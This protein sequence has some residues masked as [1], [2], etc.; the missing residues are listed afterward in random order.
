LGWATRVGSTLAFYNREGR[1]TA[2]ARRELLPPNTGMGVLAVLR[3]LSGNPIG[4]I[5][6]H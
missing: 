4:T 5:A 1:E 3:D 6:R 2:T